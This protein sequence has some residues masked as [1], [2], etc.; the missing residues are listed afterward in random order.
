MSLTGGLD[1]RMIMAW[2]KPQPGSLPCYTFGGMVRDCQDVI[3]AR[4]VARACEQP[5]QVIRAGEEFLSR[6]SHY[7]ERAI[8]LTDG[9]VDV[10]RSPDLYLNVMAR[11]IAPV[12]MTGNYGGECFAGCAHSSQSNLPGL[13]AP[14]FLRHTRQ[15]TETYAGLSWEPCFLCRLQ[16]VPVAS[17][18]SAGSGTDAAFNAIAL[19]RQ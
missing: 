16:A 17:L 3:V 15:A 7:A 13:F 12:R 18:R 9:C 2:Q 11:E 4:E 5:Y 19:P 14:E 6:F 10:S 1:T 8:Y